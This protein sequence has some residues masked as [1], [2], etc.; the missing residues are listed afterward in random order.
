VGVRADI[1]PGS[2]GAV[3]GFV[4]TVADLSEAK[5]AEAARRQLEQS[6][7]HTAS[8]GDVAPE[9]DD[10][11]RALIANASVAAMDIADGASGVSAVTL[12]HELEAATRRA[13][14]LYGEVRRLTL[15][16]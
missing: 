5:R 16:S 3:L 10:V 11:L 1:V 7:S 13:A 6:L 4:L 8:A 14:D 9:T 12:L 15:R 2:Q